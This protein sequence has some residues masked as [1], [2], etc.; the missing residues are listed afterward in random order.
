MT[1]YA[2][3]FLLLLACVFQPLT[4]QGDIFSFV[5]ENG[6][7]RFTNAPVSKRYQHF[8]SAQD[9]TGSKLSPPARRSS[10]SRFDGYIQR[11]ARRYQV[12]PL[13]IKAVIETE[14]NFNP[15]AISAKG[16][17]GLMQLMPKTAGEVRVYDPFDP[18][19]NIYGGTRYLRKMLNIFKG[20]VALS[21]A[22]YNAGPNKVTATGTIP[23][24]PETQRYVRKVLRLYKH[25]RRQLRSSSLARHS[26]LGQGKIAIR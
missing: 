3:C 7:R 19:Q 4:A 26:S 1:L 24:I 18:R 5:D 22:A 11:A 17:R 14:S 16:A 15:R 10:A 13:L 25:Y 8:L 6:V 23:K 21:L 9:R 2:S 20:D 12:D